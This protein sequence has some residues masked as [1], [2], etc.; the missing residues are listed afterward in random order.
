MLI[1]SR[2][3][4]IVPQFDGEQRCL[5]PKIHS[6]ARHDPTRP[7]YAPELE[8]VPITKNK[9]REP[10]QIQMPRR[11]RM[12][13]A[14]LEEGQASKRKRTKDAVDQSFQNGARPAGRKI[15]D[16]NA[17]RTGLED[18][19]VATDAELADTETSL[20]KRRTE[21]EKKK[22]AV[23]VTTAEKMATSRVALRANAS[24]APDHA[25]RA[26]SSCARSRSRRRRP[27]ER[28]PELDAAPITNQDRKRWRC[29]RAEEQISA[30]TASGGGQ[31][32][33]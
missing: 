10:I 20:E 5:S 1:A 17:R 7:S 27:S 31:T 23:E 26:T 4:R 8:A 6:P 28:R 19:L 24:P 3:L 25:R 21:T 12:D 29:R 2:S 14:K 32:G 18:K 15:D 16:L 9:G 13:I 30:E 33:W 22:A 11:R